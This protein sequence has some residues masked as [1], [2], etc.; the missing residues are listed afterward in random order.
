MQ[1]LN[2]LYYFVKA[3]EYGGFAAAGRALGIPKSK[4]SRRIAMLEERL[5]VRLIQRSTRHFQ[6]TEVGQRYFEH[7]SAMLVE[8]EAAQEAIDIVQ[9]EPRGLIRLTCPVGLLHFHVGQMLADFMR[10]YPDVVI[11]LEATNRRV[12]VM[13]EGVDIALRVRPLPLENSDLVLR[14]LSDRGQCLVASADLVKQMGG[15]PDQPEALQQWPSLSRA[16]RQEQH[17]W[18]LQHRDGR[19]QDVPFMPRYSTTDMVALKTAAM[20]GI[21]VV[22]LPLLMLA[23]ELQSGALVSV[24]PEWE[25]RREVIHLVFPSRRGMLPAVRALIDFLVEHYA[26]I[27]EN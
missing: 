6:M 14:V 8:A 16:A 13:A 11:D 1:D 25:P 3:V 10:Q 5:G 24:L 7:C 19:K 4:L 15:L 23:D 12:D 26:R 9:A 20:A 2:D 21:G 22:Q 18:R 17:V 27:E